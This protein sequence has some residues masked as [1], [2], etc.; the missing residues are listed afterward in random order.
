MK[1]ITFT[2]FLSV[3]LLACQPEQTTAIDPSSE[4]PIKG[5][6]KLYAMDVKDSLDQWT[7]WRGGMQ[8]YL[9]YDGD[10]HMA[11]HLIPIGY[12]D[13]DLEFP[14]FTDTISIEA[15][16]YITNNYNYFGTYT[17]DIDDQIINHN[18]ISHSNPKDWH[19][20]VKRRFEFNG[21]TL[22]IKPVEKENAKLRLKLLKEN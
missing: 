13:T 17:V 5:L 21:D 20:S 16:K 3:I 14:N 2:A 15:L 18:R 11:L 6:W 9:L 10:G 8:G 1:K 4:D 19:T 7:A 22:V 12:E